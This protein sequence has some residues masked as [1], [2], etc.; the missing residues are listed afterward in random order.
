MQ[1]KSLKLGLHRETLVWLDYDR[2]A[3]I[4]AAAVGSKGS[5]CLNSGCT[6]CSC[7]LGCTI[8]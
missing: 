1:K 2:I 3:G 4:A 7:D 5:D 8:A 6:K